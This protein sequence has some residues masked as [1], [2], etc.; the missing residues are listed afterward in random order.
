MIDM[1]EV[2]QWDIYNWGEALR[3]WSEAIR[4]LDPIRSRTL[5]LGERGGGLSLWLADQGFEVY[6]TDNGGIKDHVLEIH[7]AHRPKGQIHYRDVNIFDIPFEDEYFDLVIC[8][9]VIG[10]LKLK[11]RDAST[12][13][14]ENQKKAVDEIFRVLKPHGH[15]LGAENME[16]HPLIR[17]IRKWYKKDRIGWRHLA[18]SEIPYLFDSFQKLD[19]RFFGILPGVL[20]VDILNRLLFTFN[21]VAGS[22]MSDRSKYI[23]FIIAQK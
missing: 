13:T 10:G 9:S 18:T 11:A 7:R 5:A 20:P 17:R 8:K 15:F 6:C 12:R 2:I 21:K 22:L 3:F 23:S 19:T 1:R 4:H 16:G 14:L